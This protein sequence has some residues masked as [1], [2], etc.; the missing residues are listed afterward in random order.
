[1]PQVQGQ[2]SSRQPSASNGDD[3]AAV[4]LLQEE[5]A[6]HMKL[7]SNQFFSEKIAHEL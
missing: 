1:M 7:A 6:Q 5:F 2:H 4:A 3:A